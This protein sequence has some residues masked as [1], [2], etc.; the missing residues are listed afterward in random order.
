MLPAVLLAIGYGQ[1]IPP[2]TC[3]K[4]DAACNRWGNVF[5]PFR[6]PAARNDRDSAVAAPCVNNFKCPV[7]VGCAGCAFADIDNIKEAIQPQ[8]IAAFGRLDK[9]P[10]FGAAPGKGFPRLEVQAVAV[11]RHQMII[12]FAAEVAFAGG[13]LT[14][15]VKH[16]FRVLGEC[17]GF[18]M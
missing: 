15:D 16:P 13:G 2:F 12:D 3:R 10:V 6:R 5:Q 18:Q 9:L 17:T 7:K 11:I 14:A 1:E 8:D 4:F